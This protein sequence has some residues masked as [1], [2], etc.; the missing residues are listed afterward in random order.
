MAKEFEKKEAKQK[1]KKVTWSFISSLET[2]KE[3]KEYAAKYNMSL[4]EYIEAIHK[5]YVES[6]QKK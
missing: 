6:I 4:G 3:L 1:P 2:G 5:R